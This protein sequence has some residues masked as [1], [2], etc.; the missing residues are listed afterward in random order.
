MTKVCSKS[1]FFNHSLTGKALLII[2]LMFSGFPESTFAQKPFKI[3]IDAGHGGKDPGRPNKSG[4]KEKDIVLKIALDLGK[5][6]ENSGN[7]VIYTRD[8]DIFLTLR[9]RAKIANDVDA[10]LFI[11]IHCNAFHDSSVH[12]SETFV[13]GLHV[14]EANFNIAKKENEI[15]FLDDHYLDD[16]ET[17]SP[18][19][20]E[21]LIG[22]TLMQEEYLDQSILLASFV[23]NNFT[24]NLKIRN[25]GVK[26]SGFWVLHNTYMPSILIEAGF[27]TNPKEGA[28]L[29][30]KKGQ[31]E[32][33]NS[34]YDAIIKYKK[35]INYSGDF[36]IKPNIQ[37]SITYKVQ[38]AAGKRRLELKSYN[39]K[40][41]SNLSRIKQGSIYKYFYS[42][43]KSLTEIKKKKKYAR[44]NGFPNAYIVGFENGKLFEVD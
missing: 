29:N 16:E 32:I 12:G 23:Q 44:A 36:E 3:V 14:S 37:N 28:Y 40:G 2:I 43:S 31:V 42:S 34:I 5:K 39:F 20:T 30:S 17:Y 35:A 38:I 1:L 15:N 33:S 7:E 41:L 25:R 18:T 9:Q 4:I 6:L 27:M 19:S 22:T 21:S 10:D 11:S 8:K 26:Q 13:Y 24:K